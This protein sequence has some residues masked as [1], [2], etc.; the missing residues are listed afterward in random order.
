MMERKDVWKDAFGRFHCTS[1][2]EVVEDVTETTTGHDWME[3]VAI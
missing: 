2:G 3:M 1:C